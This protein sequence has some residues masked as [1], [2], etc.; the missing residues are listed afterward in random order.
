MS[1]VINL[2]QHREETYRLT[3]V[4]SRGLQQ[5]AE[6]EIL[7][8]EGERLA[9]IGTTIRNLLDGFYTILQECGISA[10]GE[11]FDNAE[12]WDRKVAALELLRRA[13]LY[14]DL[15]C[16]PKGSSLH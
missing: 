3:K 8:P 13:A 16:W 9:M 2:R 1:S 4:V 5:T 14:C 11:L 10:V 7:T 12:N 15:K 6:R